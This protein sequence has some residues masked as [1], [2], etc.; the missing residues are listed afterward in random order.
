MRKTEA[1]E[2]AAKPNGSLPR[3]SYTGE[4]LEAILAA[5]PLVQRKAYDFAADAKRD[6]DLD[7]DD[8]GRDARMPWE[9]DGRRWHTQDRVGRNG[10]PCRWDGRIL[11]EVIDRIQQ[12]DLFSAPDWNDRSVV[13][14]RASKK[15]DGWF[16][17]AI[18]AEEWLLKMKFRTARNTFQREELIQ[19]LDLKPLND[20]AELP[21][22]GTEPRVKCRSLRGPFQEIEVRVHSYD[23][24][25]RPHF[26]E[27][28]DRAVAGFR[29]F[30][31]KVRK[32]PEELMPWKALGRKWHF[33]RRGFLKGGKPRWQPDLLEKVC[34]LVENTAPG[35]RFGWENKV[36]VPIH[37]PG[38]KAPWAGLITK[39]PDAVHLVLLG[40]KNRFP[41]GRLRELGREPQLDGSR[42]DVDTIRLRFQTVAD[43][44]KGDLKTF[45]KEHLA[46][47]T[48]A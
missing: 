33:I 12:S 24:V 7:I 30:A 13:E 31:E 40:P 5:G 14:V 44:A 20:M 17:H 34:A 32:K 42:A 1:L 16:F 21:L 36:A 41:A 15:S 23:E 2:G 45:L 28:L 10:N 18:T 29:S 8:V 9:A 26:W 43:L 25:D 19:K 38:K 11:A 37:L 3:R 27:F 48:S 4:M 35:C 22:Y 39:K 46:A 47:A 6:G